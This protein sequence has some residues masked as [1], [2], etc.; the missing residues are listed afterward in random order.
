MTRAD[1]I[2][3]TG[4][5]NVINFGTATSPAARG[6]GGSGCLEAVDL[7][8]GGSPF[9]GCD[10]ADDSGVLRYVRVE[11]AERGQ[12]PEA[13]A[14]YRQALQLRPDHADALTNL[15]VLLAQQ[16]QR[17]EA[18]THFQAA[19]RARPG[20]PQAHHNLGVALAHGQAQCHR[21]GGLL[22]APG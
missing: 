10:G 11:Y 7:A 17:E 14:H 6:N 9:G 12:V 1:A 16:G 4:G 5:T 20:Y 13:Q 22:P 3:L 21:P 18:I 19:I 2:M 15:G 8:V